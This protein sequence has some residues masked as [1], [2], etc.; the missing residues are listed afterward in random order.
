MGLSFLW[1]VRFLDRVGGGEEDWLIDYAMRNQKT[2]PPPSP[3]RSEPETLK[4]KASDS[5][6]YTNGSG[7]LGGGDGEGDEK[8]DY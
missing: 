2:N 8:P 6:Y 3:N 5:I 7:D 1:M 4:P